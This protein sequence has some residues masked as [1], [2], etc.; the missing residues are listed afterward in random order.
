VSD[1]RPRLSIIVPTRNRP[2]ML[3]RC[4][5]SV[6]AAMGPADELI[7]ADSASD[8]PDTIARVI[9]S[10]GGSVVRCDLPGVCRAR[11]AG[12]RASNAPL[13]GY[14]DDDVVVDPG[15]ADAIVASFAAHPETAFLT[16]RTG[17]PPGTPEP[18]R[19]V[20]VKNTPE[21]AVL[22]RDFRGELGHSANM[23]IRS[24]ALAAVGGWDES[25]G[26]GGRF[27]S[28]PEV[29]LFDRLL[30]RGLN[31]RYDPTVQAW[32]EQWRNDSELVRLDWRYGI[33]NGARLS[34]LVRSDRSRARHIA[35][36]ALWDWGLVK[37]GHELRLGHERAAVMALTRV[38]GTATGFFKGIVVKVQNGH[39]K[40]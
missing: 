22:D 2:D 26:A 39:F 24:E 30:R 36:E 18:L 7:V 16:G 31:G 33:G 9:K 4:L 5:A 8:E 27:R 15:W 34:K 21:P 14:T 12:W 25:L 1:S 3:D 29:D 40:T 17:W 20:A 35:R 10:H 38:A 37:A 32:H 13:L 6:T 19:P 28:G 11:N 23:A